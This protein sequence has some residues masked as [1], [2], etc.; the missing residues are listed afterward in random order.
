M[1]HAKKPLESIFRYSNL[2]EGCN[3]VIEVEQ[4]LKPEP[5]MRSGAEFLHGL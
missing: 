1:C 3:N 4:P 2:A 5:A